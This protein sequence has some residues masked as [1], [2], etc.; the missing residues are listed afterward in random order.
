M[1]GALP[2]FI[3]LMASLGLDNDAKP[4]LESPPRITTSRSRS[5]SCSSVSSLGSSNPGCSPTSPSF[6]IS[7]ESIPRDVDA[8]RRHSSFRLRTVRFSP[9]ISPGSSARESTSSTSLAPSVEE[10]ENKRRS[11]SPRSSPGRNRPLS[12]QFAKNS[13]ELHATTPISGYARRRTPQNSPTTAT[14]PH[15]AHVDRPETIVLPS[16]LPAPISH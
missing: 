16:L 13:R 12:L 4:S 15:R 8:D 9:Y 6:N 10:I 5:G 14:F 1:S 2:S 11:A 7:S 3:E